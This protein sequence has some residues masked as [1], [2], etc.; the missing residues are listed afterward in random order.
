MGIILSAHTKSEMELAGIYQIRNIINN[1]IYLG[2]SKYFSTRLRRHHSDL[3]RNRHHSYKLQRAINKYGFDNFVFEIIE[4][5]TDEYKIHILDMEQEY[6]DILEPYKY[7]YNISNDAWGGNFPGRDYIQSTKHTNRHKSKK[8]TQKEL[9]P[10]ALEQ[11]NLIELPTKTKIIDG[12]RLCFLVDESDFKELSKYNWYCSLDN[13]A[14][15][16]GN[17]FTKDQNLNY[18]MHRQ[19]M[20]FPNT[21]VKFANNCCQDCRK[22][23]MYVGIRPKEL[24]PPTAHTCYQI[25]VDTQPVLV[26]TT[27]LIPSKKNILKKIVNNEFHEFLAQKSFTIDIVLQSTDKKQILNMKKEKILEIGIEN[28]FNKSIPGEAISK[29]KGAAEKIFKSKNLEKMSEI[30]RGTNNPMSKLTEKQVKEIKLAFKESENKQSRK[31]LT[32][33]ISLYSK[34]LN[35][36]RTCISDILKGKSWKHIIV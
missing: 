21:F 35:V 8:R 12:G 17:I 5:K 6:L 3:N 22:S 20:G 10:I 28:L 36:S 19:L 25:I 13:K 33:I 29:A 30:V 2:S 18:F 16:N 7:G 27:S 26:G 1:K 4:L 11:F 23:N 14:L 32:K 31:I 15:R 34:K 9:L 24:D